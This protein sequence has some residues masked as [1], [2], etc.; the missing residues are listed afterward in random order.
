[1]PI[2]AA[3]GGP[4]SAAIIG[5]SV[6]SGAMGMSAASK[7]AKAQ[8]QA[9]A[10]SDALQREMFAKQ[11]ELQAPFREAGL[12]AQNKL[13]QYLG[14]SGSAGDAGYGRYAGD[15]GMQDFQTDPGYA[16]RLAEGN[17][18]LDRSA[19]ARGGLLS[20]GAMKAAQRYGQDMGSQEY[21]NAFNRY[22]TNRA[23]QLNPLQSLM[24]AGQ[25]GANV[26]TQAA[27]QLG[28]NLGE[29]A[30]GAGNAR[31][32]GYIGQANALSNALSTGLN[33]YQNQSFLNKMPSS[34]SMSAPRTP[35]TY[36]GF[37]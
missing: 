1:M 15:F 26:L 22:Q 25:T 20:G 35:G 8:T 34:N 5:G 12:T 36:A 4:I 3:L 7:A 23:N 2:V 19:A 29:N 11:T 33:A 9:A 6:V 18:A 10:Q 28:S 37:F 13:M 16:F 30:L 21:M 17:K 32:S 14:L 24:G 27:G 31:A